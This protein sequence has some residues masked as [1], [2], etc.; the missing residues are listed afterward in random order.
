MTFYIKKQKLTNIK[1]NQTMLHLFLNFKVLKPFLSE[2]ISGNDKK[3]ES[4]SFLLS[5]YLATERLNDELSS[6][7][8]ANF[9]IAMGSFKNS[10]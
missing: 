4:R 7:L 1:L 10:L 5:R 6:K 3:Q 8:T 2:I 9:A